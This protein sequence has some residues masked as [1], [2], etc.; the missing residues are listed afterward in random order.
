MIIKK[1]NWSI[2]VETLGNSA[3]ISG[4]N[5]GSLTL[6]ECPLF[7]AELKEITSGKTKTVT[8]CDNLKKL[9]FKKDESQFELSFE[10]T[11]NVY[12]VVSALFD[13]KGISWE[14]NVVNNSDD[15]TV[16]NVSYPTVK[17]W[18]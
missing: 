14:T 17:I 4:G 5:F 3:K 1:D 8:S 2:C 9:D 15:V 6:K 7:T 10:I 11:D 13:D 18:L 12:I 16:L